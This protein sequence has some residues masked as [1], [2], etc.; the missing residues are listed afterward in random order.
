MCSTINAV[1]ACSS[2]NACTS[3]HHLLVKSLRTE[4]VS[5]ISVSSPKVPDTSLWNEQKKEP[6]SEARGLAAATCT[7]LGQGLMAP[8]T[9]LPTWG[10]QV[11]SADVTAAGHPVLAGGWYF[12]ACTVSAAW[13]P[14]EAWAARSHGPVSITTQP[15]VLPEGFANPLHKHINES[16]TLR[17]EQ[18][19]GQLPSKKARRGYVSGSGRQYRVG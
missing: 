12:V 4:T 2:V 18:V 3:G 1:A 10:S 19:G 11:C 7:F 8:Q 15:G 16:A 9:C 13:N 6:V 5:C 14:S 17:K